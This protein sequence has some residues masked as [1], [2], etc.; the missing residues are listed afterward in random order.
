MVRRRVAPRRDPGGG[1]ER[2]KRLL[3]RRRRRRGSRFANAGPARDLSSDPDGPDAFFSRLYVHPDHWGDGI[4]TEL[5]ATVAERLAA[6]GHERVWLEVFEENERGRSF[7]ESVG[8]E[9]IGSVTETFGGQ[10]VTTVHLSA[11]IARVVD[12]T[13]AVE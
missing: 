11:P 5:T 7:Y 8:F 9:R 3:S 6:A 10:E 13:R 1:R 2:G 4:G 12:A